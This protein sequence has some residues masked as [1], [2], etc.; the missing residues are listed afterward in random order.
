VSVGAAVGNAAAVPG[1]VVP[2]RC[3]AYWVVLRVL[4]SRLLGLMLWLRLLVQLPMQRVNNRPQRRE[5]GPLDEPPNGIDAER[6]RKL[7][8]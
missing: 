3:G 1:S 7:T 6:D 8:P 2:V 4:R 5:R